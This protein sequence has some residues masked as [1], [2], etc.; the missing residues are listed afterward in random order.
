LHTDNKKGKVAMKWGT[1]AVAALFVALLL[2]ACA[3]GDGK[4]VFSPLSQTHPTQTFP[5][6]GP[7]N[8]DIEEI[9]ARPAVCLPESQLTEEINP[10]DRNIDLVMRAAQLQPTDLPIRPELGIVVS[11]WA[12]RRDLAKGDNYPLQRLEDLRVLGMLGDWFANARLGVLHGALA[13]GGPAG[14]VLSDSLL[15][16]HAVEVHT[17]FFNSAACAQQF[18]NE[19]FNRDDQEPLTFAGAEG[20]YAPADALGITE[21]AVALADQPVVIYVEVV[22]NPPTEYPPDTFWTE[23]PDAANFLYGEVDNPKLVDAKALVETL[24]NRYLSQV[25]SAPN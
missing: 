13:L 17:F 1:V 8:V 3:G 21:T 6:E 20:F 25:P 22:F 4:P 19:E 5:S 7:Y 2:A 24:A 23:Y 11:N 14:L 12:T 9:E 15:P 10:S 16:K 18:L